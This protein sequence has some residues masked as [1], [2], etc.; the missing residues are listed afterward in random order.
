MDGEHFVVER[1]ESDVEDERVGHGGGERVARDQ[2]IIRLSDRFLAEMDTNG[3]V[4]TNY[5]HP[6]GSVC[7]IN[8]E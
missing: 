5:V 2:V 3:K 1:Y 4:H 8:V 7:G 6:L